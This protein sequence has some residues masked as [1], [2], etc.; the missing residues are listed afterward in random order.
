VKRSKTNHVSLAVMLIVSS[1]VIPTLEGQVT[2]L[3]DSKA[4][5]QAFSEVR[6]LSEKDAGPLW[7]KPLYGPMIFVAPAS[8]EIITVERTVKVTSKE[9]GQ[10]SGTERQY[11]LLNAAPPN[12]LRS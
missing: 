6:L 1:L 12:L 2:R 3:I 10:S 9:L 11:I 5:R 7:G 8:R 4:A